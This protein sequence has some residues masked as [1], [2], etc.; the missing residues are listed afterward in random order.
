MGSAYTLARYQ[1]DIMLFF[2]EEQTK[3]LGLRLK[4]PGYAVHI[5]QVAKNQMTLV[6]RLTIQVIFH[7]KA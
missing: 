7:G 2:I 1:P 4:I 5:L 3:F 6:K